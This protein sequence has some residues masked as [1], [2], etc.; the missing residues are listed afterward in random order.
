MKKYILALSAAV[1][2]AA[3]AA[4]STPD[5]TEPADTLLYV[6]NA[7][8]VVITE[9]IDGVNVNVKGSGN[10]DNFQTSC[11]LPYENDAVIKTH[12][13]FSMPLSLMLSRSHDMIGLFQGLHFGFTGAIDA[14]SAMDTQMGKSFEIGIDNLIFYGHSFG[15]SG[16]NMIQVGMGINWRNYR[17]TGENRFDMDGDNVVITGYP[18]DA[19]GKFSRVKVFSLTFPISYSYSTPV[20]AIGKSNLGFK[21]SALLNWNSHA[22][23]LTHY[24]LADGTKVKENYDRI[25]QRKF[26]V[27]IQLGVQVAPAVCLYVK[28]SP[29]D[30]FK[31]GTASPKFQTI[32]TGVS[33]GF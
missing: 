24:Q 11:S 33:L 1:F 25:G 31:S 19:E 20:K 16:R 3:A 27:D 6:R 29:F 22:S 5:V 12:Q 21:V 17:M 13:S 8:R 30:L 23:M 14:P 4:A 18:E 7:S 2:S 32:S 10:D 9:S 28:Y 15:P 26:S